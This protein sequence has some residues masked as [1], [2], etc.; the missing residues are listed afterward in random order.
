MVDLSGLISITSIVLDKNSL[1]GPVPNNVC[2][3][4]EDIFLQV[5]NALCIDPGTAVGCCGE[6]TIEE[7]TAALLGTADCEE[8]SN[9]GRTADSFACSWMEEE[10]NHPSK[11]VQPRTSS[12]LT[13][14]NFLSSY[15]QLV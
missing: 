15:C 5:D 10:L 8:I 3:I 6:V 12:Y 7:V 1:T 9:A 13:V 2:A 14:S 4:S 11:D